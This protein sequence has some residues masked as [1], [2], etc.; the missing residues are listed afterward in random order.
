MGFFPNLRL[1]SIFQ[2]SHG[3][4]CGVSGSSD[5]LLLSKGKTESVD[6]LQRPTLH[7]TLR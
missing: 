2:G 4:V 3:C 5:S 1:E 6:R 7:E